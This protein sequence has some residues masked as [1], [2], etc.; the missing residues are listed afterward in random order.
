MAMIPIESITISLLHAETAIRKKSKHHQPCP[1]PIED[2]TEYDVLCGNDKAFTDHPGN[3]LFREQIKIQ[4]SAYQRAQTKQDKMKITRHIVSTLRTKYQSRFLKPKNGYFLEVN[5]I[6][7]RDKISHA[8]RFAVQQLEKREQCERPQQCEREISGSSIVSSDDDDASSAVPNLYGRQQEI[9]EGLETDSILTDEELS[10]LDSCDM[11][12]LTD[13]DLYDL[14]NEPLSDDE[15][16]T[17]Q[18]M[19]MV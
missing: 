8:L 17:V 4:T 7:A 19:E 18:A 6:A 9:L 11:A 1:H 12:L 15:W 2:P 14:L 10:T 3:L 13:D 16:E 5:D